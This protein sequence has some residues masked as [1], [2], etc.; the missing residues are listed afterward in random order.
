ML[1]IATLNGKRYHIDVGFAN[2]GAWIPMPL[3]EGAMVKGIPGI[4][5]RLA[6]RQNPHFVSDQKCWFVETRD[7]TSQQWKNGYCF[8]EVEFL[9]QDF[10]YLNYRTMSDPE[11]WFTFTLIL[12]RLWPSEDGDEVLGSLTMVN[13]AIQR[14]VGGGAAE[15]VASCKTETERVQ[16]LDKW[17]GISL[18]EEEAKGVVGC[19]IELTEN[20]AE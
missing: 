19:K 15:T 3:E 20:A 14:R 8:T 10:G 1:I 4:D 5:V 2:F 18:T 13:E 9:P 17:F 11:S 7:A 16:A 6:Y 12:T